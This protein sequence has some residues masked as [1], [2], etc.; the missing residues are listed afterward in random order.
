M[1]VENI[2]NIVF[3]VAF[4]VSIHVNVMISFFVLLVRRNLVS[5]L[6]TIKAENDDGNKEEGEGE[7]EN[8]EDDKTE[9]EEVEMTEEEIQLVNAAINFLKNIGVDI[10]NVKI[11]KVNMC[12][13]NAKVAIA[14]FKYVLTFSIV[15]QK[16]K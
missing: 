12:A 2:C 13:T 10:S 8:E 11:V 1:S 14:A 6:P 5:V 16:I 9:S 4:V 7:N 3:V 15:I